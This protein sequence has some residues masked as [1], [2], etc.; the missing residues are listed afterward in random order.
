MSKKC[1]RIG[2]GTMKILFT[3][4]WYPTEE[5][6]MLGLFVRKHAEAVVRQGGDVCV[7]YVHKIQTTGDKT[8]TE[9]V[10]EQMTAGV[11]EVYASYKQHYWRALR[12]GYDYVV[13]NWGMPDVCQVN[14]L[15]K[16]VVLPFLLKQRHKIPYILAEHWSG[17]MPKKGT[18]ASYGAMRKRLSAMA[19]EQASAVMTVSESLAK[20]MQ[21]LGLKN[22]RY[23]PLY[24]VVD[25]CFFDIPLERREKRGKTQALHV[26]CFDEDAKNICG[27]LRAIRQVAQRRED[28]QF[29]IVGTG[30]DY[31]QVRRCAEDLQFPTGMLVWWG[32]MTPKEVSERF[33]EADFFCQFS[34]YETAPIVLSE[35]MA[36]GVPI[37][38]SA[39][40]GIPEMIDGRLG[41]L[42]QAGDETD[43]AE[44]FGWLLDHHKDYEK[45]VLREVGRKYSYDEGG[46]YLMSVYESVVG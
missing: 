29:N 44:Q 2:N 10:R 37:L 19:V 14:V 41:R 13:R 33:A 21:D 46:A 1:P 27:M 3:T 4:E 31:E 43:F 35:S 26:S 20:S 7:L 45:K 23:L 22:K 42:V 28:F 32:E 8:Q 25:D 39:V 36:S 40:G 12:Q 16:D 34:N 18:Y 38:A 24:N 30:K 9:G 6:E 17:Y 15:T 11:R 5:D